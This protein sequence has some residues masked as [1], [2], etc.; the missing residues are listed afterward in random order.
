MLVRVNK[1]LQLLK[2]FAMTRSRANWRVGGTN[3]VC[4]CFKCEGCSE[5][6][7]RMLYRTVQWSMPS[8]VLN[9]TAYWLTKASV[10]NHSEVLSMETYIPIFLICFGMV[11]DT[12]N[13]VTVINVADCSIPCQKLRSM[14]A[15]MRSDD[16]GW[17][18]KMSAWQLFICLSILPL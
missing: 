10:R 13:E 12:R 6:I 9:S 16:V 5:P 17:S 2:Q 18:W 1:L 7:N 4:W 11:W 3:W 14:V 15:W 8:F